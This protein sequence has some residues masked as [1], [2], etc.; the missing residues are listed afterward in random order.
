[1]CLASHFWDLGKQCGPRSD[2]THCLLTEITIKNTIK[3]KKYTKHPLNEKWTLPIN[4]DGTVH[5]GKKGLK[6]ICC[7][8]FL[9]MKIIIFLKTIF[10]IHYNTIYSSLTFLL[11]T[12][13]HLTI[14]YVLPS[15][16]F[17]ICIWRNYLHFH[18][19]LCMFIWPL[20]II[21]SY[22][23][24]EKNHVIRKPVFGDVW[25]S[26]NQISLLKDT[27]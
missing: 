17:W 27:C 4:Q 23:H 10:T 2:A 21:S 26:K 9:N 15:N 8:S 19:P 5:W 1:M 20:W 7:G 16:W 6:I 25:P 24:Y 11:F 18:T 3:M 13:L 14:T 22:L 12:Y